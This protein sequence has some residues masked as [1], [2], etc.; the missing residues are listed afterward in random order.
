MDG[1]I[2]EYAVTGLFT[3]CYAAFGNLKSGKRERFFSG[4]K[5]DSSSI[6]DLASLTKALVTTPLICRFALSRSLALETPLGDMSKKI[7]SLFSQNRKICELNLLNLLSHRSGLPFWANFWV[8]RL[9]SGH[10]I[11]EYRSTG[12][13]HGIE[14]LSRQKIAKKPQEIYSDLGFILL[15]FF[16]EVVSEKRLE[17][18]FSRFLS[19]LGLKDDDGC[20]GFNP[21]P[22]PSMVPTGYCRIRN[23]DLCGE[24]H[25]ENCA[26]LGGVSGHAGLFGSGDT[27][28]AFLERFFP[29]PTGQFFLRLLKEQGIF[30]F[31]PF[32]GNNS[33][34]L[35]G[36][37]IIGHN[38]FT[39]TCLWLDIT[40]WN[41]AMLLTNRVISS[42]L[43]LRIMVFRKRF[44]EYCRQ[45]FSG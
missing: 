28:I 22:H 20:F 33:A 1:L 30:G 17:T 35:G 36:N 40:N 37:Q 4:K 6:F 11:E 29:S 34:F 12:L 18:L 43:P 26:S 19:E 41:F 2:E 24:V 14:V 23:R 31:R 27:I 7:V 39:G 25:D 42:R 44:F 5:I 32:T 38:G 8:N 21:T 15:G 16:L 3:S 9:Q 13:A 45:Y 10:L